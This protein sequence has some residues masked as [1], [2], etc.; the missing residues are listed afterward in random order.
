MQVTNLIFVQAINLGH[1][2]LLCTENVILVKLGI[3]IYPYNLYKAEIYYGIE[4][5]IHLQYDVPPLATFY[6]EIQREL[7]IAN[8]IEAHNKQ[9]SRELAK[10]NFLDPFLFECYKC[11]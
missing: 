10:E 4:V 2:F 5:C 6:C 1:F 3:Y 9:G 7:F 8:F 11:K